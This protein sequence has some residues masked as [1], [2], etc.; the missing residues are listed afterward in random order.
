M[1]MILNKFSSFPTKSVVGKA[2]TLI[3]NEELLCV[4]NKFTNA[5]IAEIELL[6]PQNINDVILNAQYAFRAHGND[7]PDQKYKRLILLADLL[8]D[9]IEEFIELLISEAGKP[10]QFAKIELERSVNTLKLAAE[11]AKRI[12]GNQVI[13][14][15]EQLNERLL[16]ETFSPI[17]PVLGITPFN[18]PLN[19]AMHKIGPALAAGCPIVIKA[20]PQSPLCI[21]KFAQLAQDAGLP[22][23]L[24]QVIVCKNEVAEA[25]VVDERFKLL[26]FTGSDTVG[27]HLKSIVGKKKVIL[28]LGGNAP[29]I[30]NDS[31]DLNTLADKI[32]ASVCN[33]AGQVCISAQRILIQ[34]EIKDKFIIALE[35]AFSK[36]KS[37]NPFVKDCVNGPLISPK[38]MESLEKLITDAIDQGAKI[39]CGGFPLTENPPVY[40]PT[41]LSNIT[42]NMAVRN[43]EVFA[44]IAV[45][46]FYDNFHEAIQLANDSEYGL[47][48][49][50]FTDD[51]SLAKQAFQQLNY[52]AVLINEVPSFRI[53]NMPYGGIKNSGTG[54]EG[55]SYAIKEMCE[56]K[57]LIF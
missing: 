26:S 24:L 17:G 33:Y 11:E 7:S 30:V 4:H 44:P 3:S 34:Q 55:V 42:S 39:I 52:G 50:V 46:E 1:D 47:Q 6:S 5:L 18:F 16:I 43:Q 54:R 12:E 36:I 13:S 56:Q 53:E 32:A 20:P 10:Y 14:A 31:K 21:L 38:K 37:G 41:I 27:W 2:S 28:E 15:S 40:A 35:L 51:V 8:L 45:V 29:V 49:G 57:L 9:H 25:F 22:E 48:T 23:G 19:L